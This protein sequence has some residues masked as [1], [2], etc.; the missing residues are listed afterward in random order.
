MYTARLAL[1]ASWDE[2]RGNIHPRPRTV[3]SLR[4]LPAFGF[5]IVTKGL[6][7]ARG[8]GRAVEERCCKGVARG[9]AQ[10]HGREE[11]G[12][13]WLGAGPVEER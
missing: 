11:R 2:N 9:E 8:H 4:F 13:A 7:K 10:G 12:T 3:V 1:A 6:G 5:A